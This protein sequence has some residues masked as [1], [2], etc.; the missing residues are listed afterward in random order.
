MKTKDDQLIEIMIT[1]INYLEKFSTLTSAPVK[2]SVDVFTLREQIR[3]GIDERTKDNQRVQE[4]VSEVE[5]S[6]RKEGMVEKS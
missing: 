4:T 2:I 3:R 6:I 5:D 1:Y